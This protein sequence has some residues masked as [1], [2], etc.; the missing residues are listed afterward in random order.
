[1]LIS[2]K[3]KFIFIHIPKTAGQSITKALS[4]FSTGKW[5]GK[6]SN[7][8][9]S[10][11]LLSRS[12]LNRLHIYHPHITAEEL[13]TVLG[14]KAFNNYFSFAIVR[15]PWEWQVSIYNYALK[16]PRHK[17]H[18]FIKSLGSFDK[19]IQFLSNQPNE[20]TFL[21]KP[22]VFNQNGEKLVNYIGRYEQL[23]QEF[24]SICDRIE[25][26]AQLPK[27]NVYRTKDY[28]SYYNEDTIEI[29]RKKFVSDIE[30]FK[31]DF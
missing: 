2:R 24:K 10:K 16:N 29:V 25:I 9:C 11:N 20:F 31:Y 21:Q 23:N 13:I 8:L 15:N 5:Q 3:Y 18:K 7:L 17:N 1:M 22:F 28:Y 4:P 6:I 26:S 12:F 27:L 14:E 30:A 19:Y